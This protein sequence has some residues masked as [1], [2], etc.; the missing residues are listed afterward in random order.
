[1]K[2]Q[3]YAEVNIAEYSVINLKD[4]QLIVFRT[5]VNAEY[6][7]MTLTDGAIAPLAFPDIQIDV[8]R[9]IAV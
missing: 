1:V 6:R 7:S 3:V 8:R 5:P 9:T 2:S 4:K